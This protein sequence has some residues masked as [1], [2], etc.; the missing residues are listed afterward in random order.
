MS[1]EFSRGLGTRPIQGAAGRSKSLA[2]AVASALALLLGVAHAASAPSRQLSQLTLE[3]LADITITSVSRRDERL[4]D[5]AASIYVI[6][7]G[8]IR[9]SGATSL[10]EALRL[11]PNL[12]VARLDAGQYA[13]TARGFN[14]AI[15][16][17]LLVLIDGRT[18][19]APFFSGVLWDQQ[20]VFLDDVDRIEVISGPGSTLWGTNAVNGVIN[21]V[22]RS[23]GETQGTLAVASG[24]NREAEL[25]VHHGIAL[26]ADRNVRIYAKRSQSQNTKK[27]SGTSVA[28]GWD[29]AL[30]GFRADW[31]G[32]GDDF[33]LQGSAARGKSEDR[34]VFGAVALTPVETAE[35]NLLAQWSRHRSDG[36]SLRLQG[37][38]NRSERDDAVLYRPKEEIFD[39][40]F[41]HGLQF[42][43]HGVMWGAGYR[44]AHD[45]I[46]PGFFFGFV[47]ASRTMHWASLF[48]QDEVR[49]G[50]AVVLT[51]GTRLE[52]NGFTGTEVLPSARLAWKP[53]DTQL[54]WAAASRAVRA[55]ARLDRD[56]VLPPNPPYIIA[57]GPDFVSEVANVYELGYRAQPTPDLTFSVTAFH[58]AWDR[59][60]SGQAPPGAQ[61]Q[62]MIGGNT[63]GIEGWATWQASRRWRISG[64][65]TTLHKNL[66]LDPGSADP[67][68]PSNLGNDPSY[69]WQLRSALS[70]A[71]RHD[72]DVSV[73]RVA[74]LP[75]PAVPAYTTV[76]LRYGWRVHDG[77]ELSIAV[78]D[79][80]DA[81]HPEFNAAP[82]RSEIGRSARL[83]LRWSL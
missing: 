42:G 14:N 21:V 77:L 43:R 58:T 78:R 56:I 41:Q 71:E 73:R 67:V 75:L 66:R 38:Y 26:G 29:R 55:P 25:A 65:L 79:L 7:A 76:D 82:D 10:P 5:A 16:N 69:Q 51:V 11:A 53:A 34:G 45:D 31:S 23:A 24:G 60:R 12:Q 1:T 64:G 68:G 57:G 62:N 36:S 44:R 47:P 35:S 8:D 80:F 50:D 18:I 63:S 33:M 3:E 27:A 59:L 30:A 22:T 32:A 20:D 4:I 39:L 74:A 40:E 6:T 15:G 81:G 54:L 13:I 28:D 17:K 61:V 19:Y 37:Y 46:R 49:L 70:L 9:R 72:L 52:H 48:A 2:A 83:Q